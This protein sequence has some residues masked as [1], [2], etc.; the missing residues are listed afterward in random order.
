MLIA[1]FNRSFN[2][3][4]SRVTIDGMGWEIKWQH[5][6]GAGRRAGA[7]WEKAPY[8]VGVA[9]CRGSEHSARGKRRKRWGASVEEGFHES[10]HG[11]MAPAP[12]GLEIAFFSFFFFT[13]T[14]PTQQARL[15][16]CP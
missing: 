13:T 15:S 3:S 4:S 10:N 12:R 2:V 16:E 8:V 14:A 11:S 9:S 6:W 5:L 7:R 1:G